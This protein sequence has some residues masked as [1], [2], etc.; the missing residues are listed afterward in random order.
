[1]ESERMNTRKILMGFVRILFLLTLA[2][3]VTACGEKKKEKRPVLRMVTEATFPPYEFRKGGEIMGIDPDI[4]RAVA[5]RME[6]DV[7]IID[8]KFD[9]II[10]AVSTNKADIAASGITVTE[11]RKKIIDFTI[12]YER[13]YQSI[14]VPINSKIKS[15]KDLDGVTVGVQQGT[16]GDIFIATH[17][18]KTK[19]DRFDNGALAVAALR[20]GKIDAV[21]LDASPAKIHVQTYPSEIKILNEPLTQEEYAFAISKKNKKL[22]AAVN[23]E[24]KALIDD[25]TIQAIHDKYKKAENP[26]AP[27]EPEV[28]GF[29]GKIK[30]SF[31]LNFVKDDRYMYL[32]N[33]FLV[34]IIMAAGATVLGIVLGFFVAV[35]R[36][37]ADLTGKMKIPDLLCK[38]YLTVIRGTPVVVQLLIIYFVIFSKLDANKVLVGIIAFG[39]NSGAYVAEIIRSGIMSIDRGQ[40]EAG[41]SLGLSYPK[42]M[43]FVILP[44]AFKNVLPALGNEFI[45][46]LKETSVAG[47]IALHDLTKG[48]DIIRSQ[49]YD[50]FMPL[51]AVALIYLTVVILFTRLLGSLEKWLKKNE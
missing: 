31:I 32:V 43:L 16:T 19:L 23:R 25:G 50:A 39:F 21:V 36:S 38:L 33:G 44:Q 34:T 7:Q 51:I 37:T 11:D 27:A 42:V 40:M 10:T 29:F 24:L 35:I 28:T 45:V 6:Y 12:P 48:G 46:L 14:I 13:A 30:A 1:M 26:S 17:H 41:R 20:N 8:M 18:K 4:I 5:K 47:Y 3:G 2:A 22:L 15:K 9:A 49:T